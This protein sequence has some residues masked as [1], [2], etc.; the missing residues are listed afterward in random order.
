MNYTVTICITSP[1]NGSNLSG[2]ANVTATASVVGATVGVQR[3]I[4]NLGTG[5]LLTDYSSP[6]TFIL[7]SNKWADGNYT[8]YASAL[9]RDGFTTAKASIAVGFT[10]GNKKAPVNTGTFTPSTGNP[11]ANGQPFMVAAGGDGASGEPNSTNVANLLSSLNP[12]LFLYLGDVY[13]SGSVA[14]FYNWYGTSGSNFSALRAITDPTIGNHE[15]GNKIAGAGYFDYWN[16]IP[17]YYSFNAGGWHFISL[18]SNSSKINVTSSGAEYAWLHQDLAANVLPCTIVYYHHPLFNIGPEGATTAMSSIWALLA[19]YKVSIVLNGHDHD[20]QR[21]LP[22]DGSGNPSPT[23]ITEFVAGGAGHGLQTI[24]TTDTRVAYSNSTNPAAFGVLLIQ[25]GQSSAAFSYHST[26]GGIL[27]SGTVACVPASS[28]PTPTPTVT[29]MPTNTPTPTPTATAL[30]TSTPTPTIAPTQAVTNTP[31]PAPTFTPTL[32]VTNTPTPTSTFTSTPP[33]TNTP[34]PTPIFTPT[35]AVTNS[36]TPTPTLAVTN[37]PTPTPTLTSTLASTNTPTPTLTLT[38]TLASTNTPTPTPTLTSTLASTNTPTPTL[39]FTSTLAV[40]NTPV[41][42]PTFTPTL[43]VTDTPTPTP[44]SISGQSLTFIP[45]ADTYVDSSNPTINNGSKTTLRTDG[46]P[47]VNSYL[48]FNVS[49]LAG[50]VTRVRLL[51]FANSSL[52]SGIN[53]LAV[54]DNSWDELTLTYN[55]A[56]AMGSQLATSTSIATGTWITLTVTGY[57]SADGTYSFGIT[58]PSSTALSMAARESGAN[59]SQLIIDTQ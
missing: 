56:P 16:N 59:A 1:A 4:F 15:Y 35:L 50:T 5:Y 48:R 9:M 19:Q 26:N 14:E 54:A 52:S 6:Y 33:V 55:N 32:A 40:T 10:N 3:M 12:N 44:T 51:I 13:E 38:S 17:N 2:N 43:V 34:T 47:I 7:P 22:L 30:A 18:N 29:L 20:Y 58:D 37:T 46:S 42:I 53:A 49:G 27:D 25:L 39:T 31:I 45:V 36:P 21:W 28:F 57:I 11:P 8:L 23:G 24:A 41:P